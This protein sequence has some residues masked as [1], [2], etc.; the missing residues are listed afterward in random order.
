VYDKII[1][2]GNTHDFTIHVISLPHLE[3]AEALQNYFY[4]FMQIAWMT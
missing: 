4:R 1:V 3:F 2:A